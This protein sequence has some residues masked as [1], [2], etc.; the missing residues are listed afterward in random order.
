MCGSSVK[1]S[2][3]LQSIFWLFL[4]L[5]NCRKHGVFHS[6]KVLHRTK[7]CKCYILLLTC[8]Q[9]RGQQVSVPYQMSTIYVRNRKHNFQYQAWKSLIKFK[10]KLILFVVTEYKCTD[11]Y[12]NLFYRHCF[13]IRLCIVILLPEIFSSVTSLFARYLIS[14]LPG[15]YLVWKHTTK[16]QRYVI[17]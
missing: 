17:I 5:E 4:F 12:S 11:I 8:D 1:V 2:W 13:F 10:V 7:Y 16:R 14:G 3:D 15:I 6:I 9:P